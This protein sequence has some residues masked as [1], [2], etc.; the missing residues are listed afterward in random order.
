MQASASDFDVAVSTRIVFP[1]RRGTAP[2]DDSPSGM[3]LRCA[4]CQVVEDRDNALQAANSVSVAVES[5]KPNADDIPELR[6]LFERQ[7]TPRL[8]DYAHHRL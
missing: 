4:S 2:C 6:N 1:F 8:S 3:T 5:S 7:Q